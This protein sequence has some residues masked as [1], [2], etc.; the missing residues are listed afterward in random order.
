MEYENK[1]AELRVML[2]TI[3][4]KLDYLYRH[5]GL[6][7]ADES[8]PVYVLRAQEMVRDGRDSEAI[9]IVREHTA[10]GM[11][12]ARAIVEDMARRIG[13]MALH[14]ESVVPPAG[15]AGAP[16]FIGNSGGNQTAV[17]DAWR[18]AVRE[19]EAQRL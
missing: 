2:D 6:E 15:V 13:R 1:F 5:V 3:S 17:E 18:R 8:V 9:K 16:D 11:L 10:V 14:I 12:E 7:Y 19:S 4:R